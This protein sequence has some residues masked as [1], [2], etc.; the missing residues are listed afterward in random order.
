MSAL[1]RNS[2]KNKNKIRYAHILKEANPAHKRF[3]RDP[4][5]MHRTW[6]HSWKKLKRT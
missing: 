6:R 4:V 3:Q 1:K 5:I 2:R